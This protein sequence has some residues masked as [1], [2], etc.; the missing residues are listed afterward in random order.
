MQ[1]QIGESE[2]PLI[3]GIG[4][5]AKAGSST[6]CALSLAM[7]ASA[8]AG[9]RTQVFDG[10]YLVSLPHYG[11]QESF[12]SKEGREFVNALRN[13]DGI[14]LASPGYHGSVSGL[15]K[16]AID[17]VEETSKD[18]RVYFDGLPV[19]LIAT[20]HGWQAAAST[21]AALRS[22]VHAL[23]GWP[24]PLGVT[25]N[26]SGAPFK[27]G[28]CND[29]TAA[30][31]LALVGQQVTEFARLRCLKPAFAGRAQAG[32]QSFATAEQLVSCNAG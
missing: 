1:I 2:H 9:A 3:I 29:A 28:R 6:E 4:G 25:L 14:I 26:T 31:Q 27:E 5:T 13:A 22:I 20:A 24:T 23:R 16:N 10:H 12:V 8:R 17:Y 32:T 19:G 21:L 11:T 15:L 7:E 30:Q 18:P